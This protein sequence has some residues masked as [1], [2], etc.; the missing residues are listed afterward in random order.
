MHLNSVSVLKSLK[1]FHFCRHGAAGTFQIY[2]AKQSM[3]TLTEGP[4]SC[5]CEGKQRLQRDAINLEVPLCKSEL[6]CI[7]CGN[8]I[9]KWQGQ[10]NTETDGRFLQL[11][12]N[13][14]FRQAA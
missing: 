12:V 7:I 8:S 13:S 14:A 10:E 11:K 9:R 2:T 5:W 4:C 3:S 1:S 6:K